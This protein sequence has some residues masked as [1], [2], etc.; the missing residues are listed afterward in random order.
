M[1]ILQTLGICILFQSICLAGGKDVDLLLVAG[2]SNAVG[3][4][5]SP[6]QLPEDPADKKVMFWL[7]SDLCHPHILDTDRF[8][9]QGHFLLKAVA[10]G[11]QTHPLIAAVGR[12]ATTVGQG[13][14]GQGDDL[15]GSGFDMGAPSLGERDFRGLALAGHLDLQGNVSLWLP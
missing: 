4:D 6:D 1:K 11:F 12:P 14:S 15:E 3:F 9:K 10:L 2:Q 13:I 5:T 7:G 8:P